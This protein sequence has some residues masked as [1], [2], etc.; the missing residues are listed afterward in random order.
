MSTK[1]ADTEII[2][3]GLDGKPVPGVKVSVNLQ[4]IYWN[5]VR[6]AEGNGFYTWETEK[7]EAQ[8]GSFEITTQAS[9][10]PLHVPLKSGGLYT[11]TATARDAAGHST[12]TQAQ[13]YVVGAGYTAWERY[14]HNR[15]DLVPERKTLKP[16]QT[17]RI[18]IKSPWEHATALLTTEREGV[19]SWK[20][21]E[22]TSTQQTISVP[23][24]EA[25]IPNVFVSVLLVKGRTKDTTTE[26]DSDPG[27]PT[28]RLGYVELKVEDTA[29]R[30]KVSVKAN[31]DE[32]RPASKA[33][34]EVEVHDQMGAGTRSEVTLWAVDYG[35]LSLTDYRTPDVLGT[36]Y[37]E[38]ALQV[39]N[40]DSRQK[41]IS[42]R[43]LTPKGAAEGGGGGREEG[44]GMIRKDFRVLAFWLGS[45]TTD[46]RGR[47]RTTVTLPESL[48]TYRIMAV[49]AD[50][51]SRFG[52]GQ[53]EIRINKPV[54]LTQ[55]FPRFLAVGDKALFGAVIHSQLTRKGT[56]KV[57]IRSLDPD[58]LEV[59]GEPAATAE[60]DAKGS[61]EV[62][63][64]GVAKS[65][66]SARIQMSV[67]ML[68]ETDA[69]EDNIPVRVLL[70]PETFA[71]YG[72][73]GEASGTAQGKEMLEIPS[74]VA[75]GFGG[76]HMDLA[77]TALV[78]L[79]EGAR[80][81][82]D[83]PYGCAE[84]RASAALALVYVSELGDTFKLPGVD[85]ANA[86]KIATATVNELPKFQCEGGGFSFWAGECA[87]QSAYL[88]SYVVH[89]LQIAK[90]DGYPVDQKVLDRAYE[91]LERELAKPRPDNESWWPAY[92][93]WQAFA[94]KTL[95]EGG[96][97]EDSHI[98][99]LST[100]VDRMPVFGLSY[101]AD[102]L[103]A[104]GE[105]GPRLDDL[106]RRISNAILP[107]GG[108]AHVEELTDPYL[109]W[110][111]NSNVRTTA[112]ALDTLVRNGADRE[113][114]TRMVRWMMK[115]RR[116]GRWGNTQENAWAMEALDRLL[117][118]VRVRHARLQRRRRN[119]QGDRCHRAVPRPV[120]RS[121]EPRLGDGRRSEDRA[122]GDSGS[123]D[124]HARRDRDAVL[125]ASAAIRAEHHPARSHG[126][127][128]RSRA[129][130]R[131]AEFQ[132]QRDDVQGR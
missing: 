47:A 96:R 84:Q 126:S 87:S 54:L 116:D 9:P 89:V 77:S 15:I 80:Y 53:N 2:A 122:A 16:G 123:G 127:G 72:T 14:D 99:R 62:R 33:K 31:R 40:E 19:R 50:K 85:A 124:V 36:V 106:H 75:P 58:I 76:L 73:V 79:G 8:A 131:A 57:T 102:A 12:A 105:H 25:D 95:V 121:E 100:Y 1:G 11:L 17:A 41:I 5:S 48:T 55:T 28:F 118:Q 86:K 104:K 42:R 101:L 113:L 109:M 20:E 66:G 68:G 71:A 119:R 52:W 43:V 67:S 130:L 108:T 97:N 46:N 18:M 59:T 13:F 35:V 111:W 110:F 92:T 93:A 34:I 69:F 91:F 56:A 37:L 22:L 6:R 4:Q 132:G 107:E 90:R 44:P 129:P 114:V 74:G 78:G 27:K 65:V 128:L 61:A 30:L 21:F 70:S 81:L 64:N 23:I 29:K 63:F 60:V 51:Q 117:P 24:T 49:A 32:Y 10:V 120:G 125:R 38:K 112:I 7:K 82:V 3:V 98:T 103:I 26:D 39:V 88:T 83:Y 45:I 94:V 115:V